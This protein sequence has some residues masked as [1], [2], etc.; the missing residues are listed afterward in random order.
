METIEYDVN[1]GLAVITLNRPD[2]M[3]ALNAR[4]RIE[5]LEAFTDLRDRDD[6][7]A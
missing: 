7:R 5:L 1:D 2:K 3:N 6:V 4:M